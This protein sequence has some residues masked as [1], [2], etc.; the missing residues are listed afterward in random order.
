LRPETPAVNDV[1]QLPELLNLVIPPEWEDYNGHVNIQFYTAM[2]ERGGWP[3]MEKMGVGER[4]FKE[5]QCGFFDFEHH[6][7][8]LAEIHVGDTV[9]IY[10]RL[11]A[12]NPKRFQGMMFI[13][14]QSRQQL[15][16][17]LEF[18]SGAVN[19]ALR[20]TAPFPDDIVAALEQQL[21]E[22]NKLPWSVPLCGAMS[23]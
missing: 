6:A 21:L 23:I 14:N 9:E 2:F 7:R 18:V 12:V 4:Y 15:S 22:H 16:C 8:Y 3:M 17:T 13:V 1:R 5:R 19:L 20:K 11:V 10:A